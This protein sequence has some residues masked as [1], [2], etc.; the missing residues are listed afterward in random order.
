MIQPRIIDVPEWPVYNPDGELLGHLNVYEFNDLRV[1]IAKEQ[2]EGYYAKFEDR[3]INIR[4]SGTCDCWPNGFFDQFEAPLRE[5]I[6]LRHP[7]TSKDWQERYP[8]PIVL[9]PDGWDRT[10][11]DYSWGEE[12]I[13]YKEYQR[14]L[15]LSTCMNYKNPD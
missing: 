12:L 8:N 13:S 11:Y 6:G 3:I 14:R 9:D 5:L 15:S 10:N 1:Q 7:K 2:A 4:P